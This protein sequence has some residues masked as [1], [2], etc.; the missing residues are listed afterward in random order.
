MAR[1]SVGGAFRG[2]H[3]NIRGNFRGGGRGGF[4][5]RGG[6][7]GGAAAA[8]NGRPNGRQDG[9]AAVLVTDDGGTARE[10]TFFPDRL[11]CPMRWTS[12]FAQGLR[13]LI[14]TL[15]AISRGR[16]LRECKSPGRD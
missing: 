12:L 8:G 4:R 2:K 14:L 7:R 3:G 6:A 10:S 15:F 1:G 5:P 11:Q 13:W 9:G 16:C